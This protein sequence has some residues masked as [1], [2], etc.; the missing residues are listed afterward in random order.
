MRRHLYGIRR[1]P[2][3]A[4]VV[5]RGYQHQLLR[6]LVHPDVTDVITLHYPA[7]PFSAIKHVKCTH[8]ESRLKC[9]QCGRRGGPVSL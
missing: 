7:G 3:A 6:L 9:V 5:A 4:S 2:L 1:A 8:A